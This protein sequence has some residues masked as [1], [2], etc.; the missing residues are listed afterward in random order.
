MKGHIARKRDRYYAVIYE[1]LDPVTGKERRTWHPAGTDRA[2]AEALV[3]R[4]AAE[5]DGRN[6]EVRSLTFG[7]YLTGHWLPAKR[8]ELRVST[9]RSYVHKAQRHILPT[10]GRKRLRRLRP[11]DLERLYDSML[12]PTDGTRPLAPKTV[13]EVHLIIRGALDHALRRGLVARN[14]ALA[15]SAPKLRAI[16]KV[17]QR[18]WTA[19][20]LQAFLRAAAGHRLFP[21]L[22]L[23]ANTGIRRNE[24][25]GLRWT[26]LDTDHARLSVNRGLV[27]V[28]YELHE[29]RG[30][31]SNARRCIDLDQTTLGVLAGWR[32]LQSAEY[33]AIGVDDPGWMFTTAT[34][35]R[36]HPHSISQTF[37]RIVRRAPVPVIRL[38]DLRHTHGSLLIASGVN[39]KVV[40][41]RLGHAQFVFTVETYQ[42][43]FSSMRADAAR[44]FEALLTP[45]TT[46]NPALPKAG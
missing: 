24:L 36:V 33:A 9:H 31:T 1:G 19:A 37:D 29:S 12:H 6:D 45:G 32:A 28:G 35:E 38:H 41:E 2:E 10:L 14:V 16:P 8:L 11:E 17:E 26:D 7:A 22:W 30:K 42:H 44:V 23:S 21:A 18:A 5:R 39:A 40:S 27:A 3:A 20:E 4:L 25:L 46:E 15:A 34:G 43:T 13:Y